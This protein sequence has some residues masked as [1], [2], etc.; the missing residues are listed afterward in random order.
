MYS[1]QIDEKQKPGVSKDLFSV[2]ERKL[3]EEQSESIERSITEQELL[4]ALKS[5]QKGK[6]PGSGWFTAEFSKLFWQ[7]ITILLLNS[8]NVA[9]FIRKENKIGDTIHKISQSHADDHFLQFVMGSIYAT[10]ARRFAA[11]APTSSL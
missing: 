2:T 11:I 1:S 9:C 4:T 3:T 5:T 10:L 6:S 7:E 8:I